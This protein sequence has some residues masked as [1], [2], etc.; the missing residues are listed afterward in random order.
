MS[1]HEKNRLP[2]LRI[3]F[4]WGNAVTT[5]RTT[6]NLSQLSRPESLGDG[7][8]LPATVR[9]AI[10]LNRQ[11]GNKNLGVDRLSVV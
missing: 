3:E 7:M 6:N 11:M 8:I 4:L 5:T 9:D 2:I 1:G 10:P